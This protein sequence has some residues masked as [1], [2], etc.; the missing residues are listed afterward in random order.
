MQN[1]KI[2]VIIGAVILLSLVTAIGIFNHRIEQKQLEN[3]QIQLQLK[4]YEQRIPDLLKQL[5]SEKSNNKK[6]EQE[7]E[8]TQ[9]DYKALQARKAEE[10]R[11]AQERANNPVLAAPEAPANVSGNAALG[12]QMAA[13]RGWVGSEWA[14]L[15]S[16]W[17]K[18][19][20]WNHLVANYQ[21]SG[22][23]GIPQALP[24]SKMASHGADWATNPSTQIAWGLD[25]I[26]TRYTTPC[27]A[28]QHSQAVGW[29]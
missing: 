25:Y 5:D 10:Q 11:I 6:I 9:A 27:G 16:L 15:N 26:A 7:L 3:Q 24:G 20:G 1:R 12:Q 28:W 4:E 17:G 18:E 21:G 29:Y 19:S 22:A 23:Y 13:A 14:C 8:R 2:K